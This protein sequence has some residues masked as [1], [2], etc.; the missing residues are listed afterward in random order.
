MRSA[1]RAFAHQGQSPA[2]LMADLNRFTADVSQGEFATMVAAIFDHDSNLLSYCS[3]GHPP[4]LLRR[5]DSDEV[6]RLS[7]AS[8]PVLGPFEDSAYTEGTVQVRP[9]DVLVMYTDGLVEHQGHT[10]QA[11][12]TYLEQVISACQP[13]ALLDCEALADRVAPS[14]RSDD[15]CILVIRFAAADLPAAY[16]GTSA[17][18]PVS[19]NPIQSRVSGSPANPD[20]ARQRRL[21]PQLGSKLFGRKHSA[22]G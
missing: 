18:Y 15:I 5:G 10:V 16:T 3:A 8:G 12:I 11:G 4:L 2:G 7:G 13:E 6:I 9:G 17:D 22:G 14:P 20:R 21:Q 1:G 19:T